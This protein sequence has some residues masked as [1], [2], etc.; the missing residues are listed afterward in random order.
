MGNFSSYNECFYC[1][2]SFI[3]HTKTAGWVIGLRLKVTNYT[4]KGNLPPLPG[5]SLMT[6]IVG[7]GFG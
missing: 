3:P 7:N 4:L 6:V 5:F 2:P 1:Y